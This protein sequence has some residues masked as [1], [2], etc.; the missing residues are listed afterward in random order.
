MQFHVGVG[1]QQ[2]QLARSPT[3]SAPRDWATNQRIHMEGP[4][5]LVAYVVEDGFVGHQWEERPLGLRWFD[6]LV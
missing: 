4:R 6:A 5:T 3:P 2:C 1:V